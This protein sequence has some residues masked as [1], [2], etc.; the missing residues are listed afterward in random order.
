[1]RPEMLGTPLDVHFQTIQSAGG[2]IFPNAPI[3]G[4][5]ADDFKHEMV[6]VNDTTS[7]DANIS[8]W[9]SA[10]GVQAGMGNTSDYRFASYRAYDVHFVS[11][12]DDRFPHAM[13]PPGAYWYPARI[14]WGHSY[15]VV[16][17]GNS[18]TFTTNVAAKFKILEGGINSLDGQSG[19]NC[20]LTGR[21]LQPKKSGAIF[22][23]TDQQV[24]ASYDE[25]GAPP[26]PVFVEYRLI[27]GITPPAPGA[28]PW[29]TPYTV[30][31]QYK[32]VFINY[33]TNMFRVHYG[34]QG[35]CKINGQQQAGTIAQAINGDEGT[36]GTQLSSNYSATFTAAPGDRISCGLQ[37]SFSGM[38]KSGPIPTAGMPD[39]TLANPGTYTGSFPG[40]NADT[41]YTVNY[42]VIVRPQ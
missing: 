19:I 25:I 9:G 41:Q 37:G 24:R 33:Q 6:E 5:Q 11:V 8:A 27:P 34:A 39:F 32:S 16:C 20:K 42:T 35:F 29:L 13:A 2:S 26:A 23:G 28:I 31:V 40:T 10:F 7:F 36:T 1:M 14:Y 38:A 17:S 22:A 18:H 15:E 4:M 12:V 30:E 21:G 3:T